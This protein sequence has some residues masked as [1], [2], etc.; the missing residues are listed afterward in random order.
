MAMD[1]VD[2]AIRAGGLP[3]V[4]SATAALKLHGWLEPKGN[5]SDSLAVHGSD[6]PAL[7]ALCAEQPEWSVPL[8]P[9]L[10]YLAGEVVWAARNEAARCVH[11]VLSRRT[12][13]LFLDARASIEAAPKVA[14]LLAREL[15]REPSWQD[16]QTAVFTKLA[17]GYLPET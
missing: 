10:P 12:R 3:H 14:A 1:A 4:P 17:A 8:H 13:A 16:H 5:G 11:D 6:A 2:C 7:A 9:S 15:G